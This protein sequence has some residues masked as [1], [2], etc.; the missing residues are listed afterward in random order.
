MCIRPHIAFAL[1]VI[2]R[3][4]TAPLQ[5]GMKQIKRLLRYFNGSHASCITYGQC[6]LERL[7]LG[8]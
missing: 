8:G 5:F 6:Q 4:H 7:D 1:S 3:H 2:S